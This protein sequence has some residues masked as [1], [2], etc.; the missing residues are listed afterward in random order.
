MNLS[1]NINVVMTTQIIPLIPDHFLSK[2]S[3]KSQIIYIIVVILTLALVVSLPWI[4]VSVNVK[5]FALIRPATEISPIRSLVNGRIKQ[6]FV[7]ENQLVKKGD[8]LYVIES[9]LLQG[10]EKLLL[11]KIEENVELQQTIYTIALLCLAQMQL[12]NLNMQHLITLESG[13]GDKQ[14]T[15]F[16]PVQHHLARW[17]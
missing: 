12:C 8:V 11:L 5:S 1:H 17:N 16:E 3:G 2:P 15:D 9:D 14:L 6:S 13:I 4:L 10:R 7:R